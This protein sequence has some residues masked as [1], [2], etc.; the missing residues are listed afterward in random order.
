MVILAVTHFIPL[1][2]LLLVMVAKRVKTEEEI[3]GEHC[4]VLEPLKQVEGG[5]IKLSPLKE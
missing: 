2:V 5:L 4:T 1:V 3:F